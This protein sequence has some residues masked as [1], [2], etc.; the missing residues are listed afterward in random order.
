MRVLINCT[1]FVLNNSHSKKEERDVITNV[2]WS[3]HKVPFT[4]IFV[5]LMK[6]ELSLQIFEKSLN[7]KFDENPSS[8]SRVFPRGRTDG[9]TNMIMLIVVFRNFANESN[10]LLV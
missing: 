8:G 10:N 7:V 5:I 1:I 6:V 3:S 4:T 9:W 2:Y